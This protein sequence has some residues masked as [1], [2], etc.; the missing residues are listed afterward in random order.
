MARLVLLHMPDFMV[1]F[2]DPGLDMASGLSNVQLSTFNGSLYVIVVLISWSC[3]KG[4]RKL[5]FSD[6]EMPTLCYVRTAL[7]GFVEGVRTKSR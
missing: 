7:C 4:Q 5:E 1:V 3:C 2:I 6:G